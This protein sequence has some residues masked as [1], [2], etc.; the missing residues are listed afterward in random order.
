M[1]WRI[2][3]LLIVLVISSKTSSVKISTTGYH[4]VHNEH[5]EN[6]FQGYKYPS[7]TLQLAAPLALPLTG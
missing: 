3:H 4:I 1:N 6:G 5:K 7:T 2:L